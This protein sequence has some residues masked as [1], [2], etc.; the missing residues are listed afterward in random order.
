[1]GYKELFTEEEILEI[2]ETLLGAMGCKRTDFNDPLWNDFNFV[3][4]ALSHF[5]YGDGF[6]LLDEFVSET[7]YDNMLIVCEII[8][9]L[10][11]ANNHLDVDYLLGRVP[12]HAWHEQSFMFLHNVMCADISA[13]KYAPEE[14]LTD[15]VILAAITQVPHQAD[16]V[17]ED[18]ILGYKTIIECTP[19][20][21]W[22]NN[23]FTEKFKE[24]MRYVFSYI[25][26]P[27]DMDEILS[28][29][30]SKTK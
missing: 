4:N 9:N 26:R 21:L 17:E 6:W 19:V 20:H 2:E 30:D 28:I 1:M 18:Y 5:Q 25:N 29:I 12:E 22:K 15:E 11:A 13:L 8:H 27:D 3:Y 24:K 16:F 10:R 23:D 14:L 7:F